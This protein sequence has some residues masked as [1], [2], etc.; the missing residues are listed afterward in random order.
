MP[1]RVRN[2][3]DTIKVLQRFNL[4][5]G[6]QPRVSPGWLT[7]Q[8]SFVGSCLGLGTD[9][10]DLLYAP[11]SACTHSMWSHVA[12]YNLE[13][14]ACALHRMHQIPTAGNFAMDPHYLCLAAKYVQKTFKAF[15]KALGIDIGE[16]NLYEVVLDDLERISSDGGPDSGAAT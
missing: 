11:F 4:L 6:L 9:F 3:L 16:R 12:L 5:P 13:R 10:Y 8:S 14:C 15:D 1:T 2:E 7:S